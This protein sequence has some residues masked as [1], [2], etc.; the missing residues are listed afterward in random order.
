MS[1]KVTISSIT[2]NTP[3]DIYYCDSMSAN[4]ISVSTVGTFPYTFNVPPPYD[5][6][7]IY[8]KI[9]DIK[10][11][12]YGEIIDVTPT[13][14]MTPTLTITPTQTITPT[15]TPTT[16]VTPTFTPTLTPTITPTLTITPTQTITPTI[17]ASAH[18]RGTGEHS[19]PGLACE[20]ILTIQNYYTYIYEADLVPVIGVVVYTVNNGIGLFVPFVGNSQWIKLQFDGNDYAVQINNLGEIENFELCP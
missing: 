3:V 19:Q 7:D 13:P 4:C 9:I 12:E 20:S 10:G 16:T 11:C 5:Q 2:A 1:R 8:V 15:I 6:E 14:T 18:R 17:F